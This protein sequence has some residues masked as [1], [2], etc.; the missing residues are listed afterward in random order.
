MKRIWYILCLFIILINTAN[1]QIIDTVAIVKIDNYNK[2]ASNQLEF[3][4]YLKRLSDKW[5]YFANSTFHI[6]FNDTAIQLN[7]NDFKIE[8]LATSLPFG[9]ISGG[10]VTPLN[11][12]IS[13]EKIFGDKISIGILGPDTYQE[14][15]LV[16]K[17]SLYLLGRY[18]IT[19]LNNQFLPRLLMFGQP[20]E[21]Y[22]ATAYKTDRDS[23]I[24]NSITWYYVN[25][26]IELNKDPSNFVN[27]EVSAPGKLPFAL[28]FFKVEYLST[29]Q[30]GISWQTKTEYNVAGYIVARALRASRIYNPDKLSYDTILSWKPGVHFNSAMIGKGNSPLGNYY[31]E[32]LDTIQY[33]DVEYCYRLYANFIDE[34]GNITPDSLL[35][36]A[37]VPIPN[38]VIVEANP[39]PN[40]FKDKTTIKYKL[41]DDVYLTVYVTDPTGR[42]VRKLNDKETGKLLDNT[43]QT[44]G[45]HETVF[46]PPPYVS[47]GVY[48]II[49]I[50]YP[51]ED[52]N[53]EISRSIVKVILMR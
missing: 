26:N 30:N 41:D 42:I 31:G 34:Y 38:A 40:P 4:I 2:P 1:S 21:Y 48:E 18:R 24:D 50:A 53:V 52:P 20:I 25:D 23:I 22:Q 8:R 39:S 37:C 9:V 29:L 6:K 15:T 12:Y 14:S 44:R 45:V 28:D 17:D 33:R 13:S 3:D 36:Q 35:A 16:P 46:E 49:F 27:Y 32:F 51:I 5:A 43:R 47:V 10:N 7:S 11:G 19:A